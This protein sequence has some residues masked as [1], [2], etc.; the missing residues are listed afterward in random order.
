[1]AKYGIPTARYAICRTIEQARK[2]LKTDFS[3]SKGAVIKPS[4]LTGGKGVV[5]CDSLQE[6]EAAIED[7]F[8]NRQNADVELYC[9]RRKLKIWAASKPRG[10]TIVSG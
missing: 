6:A 5:C 9:P 2:V 10:L 4:G 3:S 7:I 1:M 8:G